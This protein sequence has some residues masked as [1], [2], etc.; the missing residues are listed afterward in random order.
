MKKL[1]TVLIIGVL[2]VGSKYIDY[3]NYRD[4]LISENGKE[5]YNLMNQ[6]AGINSEEESFIH[7]VK[8]GI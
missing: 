8:Y 1:A 2:A 3:M 5:V 4:K 7:Y 6:E